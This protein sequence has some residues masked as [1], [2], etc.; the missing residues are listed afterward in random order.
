MDDDP[1][2]ISA[3][4]AADQ[5]VSYSMPQHEPPEMHFSE[6]EPFTLGIMTDGW[7]EN[8]NPELVDTYDRAALKSSFDEIPQPIGHNL[9]LVQDL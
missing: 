8:L 1:S 3:N 2:H 4:L 5:S 7:L 9:P 6:D